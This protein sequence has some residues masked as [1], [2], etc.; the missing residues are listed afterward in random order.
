MNRPS[1][2]CLG[3]ILTALVGVSLRAQSL[4]VTS[5]GI[6]ATAIGAATPSSG[7]FTTLS[8]SGNA[9]VGGATDKTTVMSGSANGLTVQGSA[10]PGVVVWDTS[11]TNYVGYLGQVNATTYVGSYGD[12]MLQANATSIATVSSTGISVAGAPGG[13]NA[14]VQVWTSGAYGVKV[15]QTAAGGFGFLSEAINNGG[16]YYH[17]LFR[18][19]TSSDN[20]SITSNGTATSYNTT[21]DARLKTHIRDFKDSGRLIDALRP[22]VF[23]WKSGE[24]DVIGFIAQE[25]NA[26]DPVFARIG[27]VTVGDDDPDRIT[28]QWQRSDQAL[29]PILVAEVQLLRARAATSESALAE[30]RREVAELKHGQ[31]NSAATVARLAAP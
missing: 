16:T 24:R 12:L 6:N 8:T 17:A 22:R 25:E 26:A 4:N 23:D 10:S 21:S 11:N 19:G 13:T 20:G 5:T 1:Y 31:G 27:A 30:L 15:N 14:N 3:V 9:Q 29:V 7:A 28:R 18:A 2:I